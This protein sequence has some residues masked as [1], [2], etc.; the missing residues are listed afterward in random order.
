LCG[1]GGVTVRSSIVLTQKLPKLSKDT[2]L[3]S[4]NASLVAPKRACKLFRKVSCDKPERVFARGISSFNVIV[5]FSIYYLYLFE[6]IC[7][8]L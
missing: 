5:L 4:S 7:I 8:S 1:G 3:P 2:L 6:T